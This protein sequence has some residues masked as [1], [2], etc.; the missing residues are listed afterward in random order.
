MASKFK[1]KGSGK[2]NQ[3]KIEIERGMDKYVKIR[4]I[5]LKG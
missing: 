3:C 2:N 5:Y 1:A 4:E